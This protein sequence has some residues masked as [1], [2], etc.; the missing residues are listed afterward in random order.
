[1]KTAEQI[2][3]EVRNTLDNYIGKPI[4]TENVNN[5]V[6]EITEILKED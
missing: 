5:M 2:R 6:A 4:T 3:A 1:M